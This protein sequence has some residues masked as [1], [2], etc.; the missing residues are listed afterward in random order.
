[1]KE[2]PE[3]VEMPNS[4]TYSERAAIIIASISS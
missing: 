4:Y 2:F 3:E 1:M